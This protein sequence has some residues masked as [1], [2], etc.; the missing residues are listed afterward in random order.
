MSY[1]FLDAFPY[2]NPR[3]IQAK[4]L[5]V[6]AENWDDYDVFVI[7]APTAFGKTAVAKSVM[8]AVGSVSVITPA[9]MLVKQFQ[10]EFA[11]TASLSR[12]DS[13]WCGE[14]KQP[15]SVTRGRQKGFCKG[16]D[17]S[18]DLARAKYKGGPGVYNYHTYLAHKLYRE[19]LVVDEAHNLINTIK[20]RQGL[21][22]WQHDYKYPSNMYKPEQIAAW[23]KTLPPN[24][25]KH[26]KIQI[27]MAACTSPRPEYVVQRSVEEFN[28]AGTRRGFPEDRDC[29]KMLPVDITMAPPMFWPRE[30]KK[31]VLLS[32]TIGRK[33]VEQ[34]GLDRRRVLY[35][36]CESPIPAAHRPIVPVGITSVNRQNLQ[37]STEIMAQYIDEVLAPRHVGQKGVVHITY[38]CKEY[39]RILLTG[40]RYI[41]HDRWNKAQ[42][43][44]AFRD[45]PASEGKILVA[46]GMYEGI[47]LPEDLGRWQ[48]LAK[49]P[50]MSLGSPAI[51][52]MA[53]ADPEWYL[54]D[55]WKTTMQACG[56]ISRTP[57]DFGITYILDRSFDRL[58][59][60]GKHL[61]PEWY[62]EALYNEEEALELLTK[63]S[64]G[65]VR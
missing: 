16:C 11:D 59:N 62:R 15:C 54:W 42:Q 34:L 41:F 14:W 5:R 47:D 31:V 37:Q 20:D 40:D 35:I 13:Y 3:Q 48:V 6:L 12:M 27:L 43:Y 4:A 17:C 28:G 46:S 50:W 33:D 58:Y 21:R 32:A 30:V 53:D 1:N 52:Y 56:R 49:I 8:R 61:I 26:K 19:V 10:E 36:S 38:Q 65:T 51:R 64:T 60:D 9:N 55:T 57:D 29:I 22:I 63:V 18:K 25:Q 7:S 44:Q 2:D 39:L 45:S 23:V 24:K